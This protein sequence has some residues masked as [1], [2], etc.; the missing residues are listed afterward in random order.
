MPSTSD[1]N[2]KQPDVFAYLDVI[3][4]RPGMFIGRADQDKEN[5]PEEVRKRLLVL[6]SLLRGYGAALH[7][8][9][10]DDVNVHFL[11]RLGQFIQ[12]KLGYG[13]QIGPVFAALEHNPTH[14]L[15]Q[16][17]AFVDEFRAALRADESR[18]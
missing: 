11:R 14:P 18:T 2:H 15:E 16:F 8:V 4:A 5:D 12:P 10:Y 1:S 6:D 3:R 17:W 13:N 9:G 7:Q